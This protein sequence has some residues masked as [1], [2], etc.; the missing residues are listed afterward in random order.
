MYNALR[1]TVTP[2]AAEY[3]MIN[4]DHL[5]TLVSNLALLSDP[6]PSSAI[7]AQLHE[8]G[9]DLDAAGTFYNLSRLRGEQMICRTLD[10]MNDQYEEIAVLVVGGFHQQAVTRIL[11]DKRDISWAIYS[12]NIEL[13]EVNSKFF[14]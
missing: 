2:N 13:K 5:K 10:L 4:S 14:M 9:R 6:S 7:S 12:V 3:A 8:I 1:L 11:E